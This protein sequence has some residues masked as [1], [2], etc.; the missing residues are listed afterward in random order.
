[1]PLAEQGRR[2][3]SDL[4]K[5]K[6]TRYL[7]S[8]MNLSLGASLTSSSLMATIWSPARSLFSEGPPVEERER[9]GSSGSLLGKARLGQEFSSGRTGSCKTWNM[10]EC[11]SRTGTLLGD[12]AAGPCG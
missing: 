1:M 11:G 4:A 9:Y 2:H 12:F 5:I 6:A 8:S 10:Q 3:C 7:I